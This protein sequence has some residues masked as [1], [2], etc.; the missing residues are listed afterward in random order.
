MIATAVK[1]CLKI[2]YLPS[3]TVAGECVR[4]KGHVGECRRVE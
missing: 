4:A 1:M 2:V 3:G